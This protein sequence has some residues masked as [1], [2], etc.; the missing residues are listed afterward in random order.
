PLSQRSVLVFCLFTDT[1]LCRSQWL[2]VGALGRTGDR[3]ELHGGAAPTGGAM[4]QCH[5]PC[6]LVVTGTGHVDPEDEHVARLGAGD[7][8][9]RSEEHTSELQTRENLVCRLLI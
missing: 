2:G 6:R 8:H 4:S 7:A 3:Q 5:R 1:T 9:P